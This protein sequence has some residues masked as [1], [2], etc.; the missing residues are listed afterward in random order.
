M[1]NA[2]TSINPFFAARF[3]RV[4]RA[5]TP[6]PEQPVYVRLPRAPRNASPVPHLTSLTISAGRRVWRPQLPGNCGG[7]SS[8][9][10][11]AISTVQR[12]GPDDRLRQ[13]VMK[14]YYGRRQHGGS[15]ALSH[16][17]PRRLSLSLLNQNTGKK[18]HCPEAAIRR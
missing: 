3:N 2:L 17:A 7:T 4:A 6:E 14:V 5:R 9:I 16:R 15:S 8:R 12:P 1:T 13:Q 18:E 10:C 11:C